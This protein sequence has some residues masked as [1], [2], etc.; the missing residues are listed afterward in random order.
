MTKKD[1]RTPA[2]RAVDAWG[3]EIELASD[4]RIDTSTVRQW[5]RRGTGTIPAQHHT[6]M[7]RIAKRRSLTFGVE[8]LV[9]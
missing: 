5:L 2:Q 6:P 3:S 9:Q 8:D 4:L 1:P 7:L